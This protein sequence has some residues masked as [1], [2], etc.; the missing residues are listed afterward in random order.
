MQESHKT[1]NL[2]NMNLD[3]IFDIEIV[4]ILLNNISTE[5][6]SHHSIR[7]NRLPFIVHYVIVS[8]CLIIVRNVSEEKTM[9]ELYIMCNSHS[10]TYFQQ[11]INVIFCE[12]NNL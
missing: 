8:L 7:T 6:S 12:N 9:R 3:N 4:L 10:V 11:R 5:E 1:R 2:K